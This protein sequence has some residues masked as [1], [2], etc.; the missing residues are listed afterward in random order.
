MLATV[1]VDGVRQLR[2]SAPDPEW[3]QRPDR[4]AFPIDVAPGR[5]ASVEIDHAATEWVTEA[6]AT[7]GRRFGIAAGVDVW[8]LRE[9]AATVAAHIGTR[10]VGA[11]HGTDAA[12]FDGAFRAA[13]GFDED[14]YV[15]G[16]LTRLRTE[17]VQLDI[18]VP[19]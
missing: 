12:R 18:P 19:A 14:P 9:D 2:Q 11:I 16:R 1:A 8:L 17:P 3:L 4:A 5:Y 10:R 13:A 6:F 15:E 7:T